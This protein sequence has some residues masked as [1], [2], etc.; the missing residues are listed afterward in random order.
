MRFMNTSETRHD[1]NNAANSR[2]DELNEL[3][4][5]ALQRLGIREQLIERDI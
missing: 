3:M 2:Y 5:N 1:M 4:F